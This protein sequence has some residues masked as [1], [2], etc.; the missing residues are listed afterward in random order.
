MILDGKNKVLI[1][2]WWREDYL[3]SGVVGGVPVNVIVRPVE[4]G[5]DGERERESRGRNFLRDELRVDGITTIC[6]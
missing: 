6:P 3:K 1:R 5:F 2:K 4:E